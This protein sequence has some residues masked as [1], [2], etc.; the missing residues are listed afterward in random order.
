MNALLLLIPIIAAPPADSLERPAFRDPAIPVHRRIDDLIR[1][2]TVEEKISQLLYNA[3]AVERLGIRAY[4]WWS[5]ALHG[6]ARAGKATVFPQSI[7]LAATFDTDLMHRVATATSDEARAKHHAAL[8]TGATGIYEGLTFFSPNINILRDPRWGRGMET[9]GEDPYLTSRMAIAFI[10]GM[11]GNDPRYLK[12]AAT[13]KHFAV[14]S[15][16]EPDRHRFDARVSEQ[17]LRETYLPAFRASVV[18]AHVASVMCAYNRFSGEPCCGSTALLQRIL[19]DEWKFGG[20]VVSDCWAIS[21]FWQFHRTSRDQADAAA[22]ALLAGTDVECG[23]SFDSLRTALRLGLVREADIDR[24]LRRALEVRFRLGM[25]DPPSQVPYASISMEVVDR[26]EHRRLALEAACKSIVLL[27]N[28]GGLL[29]LRK[30]LRRIAVIGPTI[31]DVDAL[32][33]NYNGT[34]LDPVTILQGIW[35]AV[36]PSTI[37]TS[38]RGCNVTEQTPIVVPVAEGALFTEAGPDRK[39]GLRAEYGALRDPRRPIETRIDGKV[40]FNWWDAAPIPSVPADSFFVHWSG[41]L[42][43]PLTGTYDL[44]ARVFGQFRLWLDDTLLT[45]YSDRHV[46]FTQTARIRLEAGREYQ[47]RLDF[48]DRRRD[49]LIQLV[50]SI[51]N[52]HALEEAVAAAKGADIA[53]V[54]LGLTPRLEG[55]EMPVQ[56]EGFAGGDRTSL[57][58]PREQEEMLK[59]V[60]AT[61]TPVVLVLMN[62]SALAIN[63]AADHVPAIVEAWYPGQAAGTAVAEVLFGDTN[64]SGRL[65]VTFFRSVEQLPPF[66]D[67]AMTNRTYRYFA[68]KPL[69][70]FG[71]GLSYTTFAY[72]ALSIPVRATTGAT[73][74]ASVTVRNTGSRSGEE[75]VQWY[76]SLEGGSGPAPL[77]SLVGFERISLAPGESRLINR[78]FTPRDLASVDGGGRM[79]QTPGRVRISAGGEQPGVR[80]RLHAVTTGT[81]SGR[82]TITGEPRVMDR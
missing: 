81:V 6:V 28:E 62:G 76:V 51:P 60:V 27:R 54:V 69:Y 29:P 18:E 21:D 13:A 80:G 52:P 73:I 3:P 74:T 24:A 49:A 66:D 9:Y 53:I 78:V 57:D 48:E 37:V 19:R 16:P 79:A 5:E 7:G 31:D 39:H 26:D 82:V 1:R 36:D 63:W 47:I 8:R 40:D 70:P 65:P 14:H 67:Y 10:R 55:E 2:L 77:R 35:N 38:A 22:T 75:V 58:L 11:Q 41:V 23:V 25:F 50:W 42:V 15:G 30:D 12:T 44:G 17:D 64:P 34:P 56:V 61:G 68:G 45:E 20:Y 71:Y 46:V 4:N 43:P 33:G 32:L 72:D 59:A